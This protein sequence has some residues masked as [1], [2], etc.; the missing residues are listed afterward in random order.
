MTSRVVYRQA[1]RAKSTCLREV[2]LRSDVRKGDGCHPSIPSVVSIAPLKKNMRWKFL[3]RNAGWKV[4][5]CGITVSSVDQEYNRNTVFV[6]AVLVCESERTVPVVAMFYDSQCTVV[7]L[8][9]LLCE[10]QCTVTVVAM[11]LCECDWLYNGCGSD[12]D[13]WEWLNSDCGSDVA[14]WGWL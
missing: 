6:V 5:Y 13:V 2:K 1:S 12:V 10:S 8:A 7:L 3:L 11:L 4:V 14:V 9:M